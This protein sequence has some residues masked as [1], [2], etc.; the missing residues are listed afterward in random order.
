MKPR[1]LGATQAY[2]LHQHDWS[3]SS[4][5]LELFTREHGRLV[6]AAKGAKK[7]TSNW[8]PVLLNFVRLQV[9]CTRSAQEEAEV[10]NLR[11]VEWAGPN[12]V[13][14]GDALYAAFYLN[15]LLLKLLPRGEPHPALFDA[16]HHT[17]PALA[18][19]DDHHAQ[20]ALRAFECLLLHQQGWLPELDRDT[21]TQQPLQGARAYT[22]QAD[23]GLQP[24]QGDA[25]AMAGTQWLALHQALQRQDL[26][27]CQAACL[28]ALAPLRS[29]LR[30]A[31]HYH[32]GA[33]ELRTRRL[34]ADAKQLLPTPQGRPAG[35]HR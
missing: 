10:H 23:A 24:A 17:L 35:P 21:S 16:Y 30:G 18:G 31:L 14:R 13:L 29:L 27:A 6:V 5:I 3:E 26:A 32:L 19:D 22:L 15:E 28:G 2:V 1:A 25:P 7:P 12:A 11:S 20:A 34:L 9:A 33:Q 8:R 4:L